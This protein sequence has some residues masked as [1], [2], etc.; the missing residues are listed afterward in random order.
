[1]ANDLGR[2]HSG[3]LNTVRL[4]LRLARAGGKARMA[5]VMIGASVGSV[6]ILI[7]ASFQH[8]LDTSWQRSL[9]RT[10]Y[11]GEAAID[12]EW[13][14]LEDGTVEVVRENRVFPT[15]TPDPKSSLYLSYGSMPHMGIDSD[16]ITRFL[17]GSGPVPPGI[18]KLPRTGEAYVSPA[19]LAKIENSSE[20]SDKFAAV[21]LLEISKAGLQNP[22][23]LFAYLPVS[24][25]S[26]YIAE[27]DEHPVLSWGV[28]YGAMHGFLNPHQ[29][30][31]FPIFVFLLLPAVVLLATT[32]R[33]ASAVRTERMAGLRLLG[34][35]K[36]RTRL[37][38]GIE[39]GG[40]AVLGVVFG[41]ALVPLIGAMT[42]G[43][44]IFEYQW[45]ASDFRPSLAAFIT[46]LLFVPVL[47]VATTLVVLRNI[48][49]NPLQTRRKGANPRPSLWRL[50]PVSF[51]AA[52]LLFTSQRGF[53]FLDDTEA[54]AAI[55]TFL[56]GAV[57]VGIGLILAVPVLVRRLAA[58]LATTTSRS[59]VLL[60][61]RRTQYEPAV[62]NR[63]VTGIVL[64]L[65]IAT[66]GQAVIL[67]FENTPQ[68]RAAYAS[69]SG[70]YAPMGVMKGDAAP[71]D[72]LGPSSSELEAIPNV[73]GATPL[74]MLRGNATS[75][76]FGDFQVRALIASCAEL[77]ELGDFDGSCIDAE[78]Q[79]LSEF[80][81][82]FS[83]LVLRN[84]DA[85]LELGSLAGEQAA[86]KFENPVL[87]SVN[88]RIPPNL[89]Q[90]AQLGT[91][92]PQ[93]WLLAVPTD[94]D[95]WEA[96]AAEIHELSPDYWAMTPDTYTLKEVANVRFGIWLGTGIA[97]SIAIFTLLITAI[98]NGIARR[99]QIAM[100]RA[101]GVSLGRVRRSQ[102][103]QALLPLA[104]G[105]PL[106]GVAGV[107]AG[108]AYIAID[109]ATSSQTYWSA[110]GITLAL[111]V[112]AA[113]LVAAATLPAIGGKITPRSLRRE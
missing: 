30:T 110:I 47:T 97:G 75:S 35:S 72:E 88:L 20:L 81:G 109:Y 50:V 92:E 68:Y 99:P 45:F 42:E 95:T 34:V 22:G 65:F 77:T 32:T 103:L 44:E 52:V 56:L 7:S 57:L 90:L 14:E 70:D 64:V 29:G 9:D 5:L 13:I 36:F 23:E 10:A 61:A 25:N 28:H 100:Q 85:Q 74:Y 112:A 18:P 71:A 62:V 48:S 87:P 79:Q 105:V 66:G 106:A 11:L 82:D 2:R 1:M 38:A 49:N 41:V 58:W 101:F 78:P 98:D 91:V 84:G 46:I 94:P 26:E 83:N 108:Q 113:I 73:H 76:T 8:A 40:L 3:L 111:A 24:G 31:S 15:G 19:L 27:T 16:V 89:P 51:G 67:A 63:L 93:D 80:Q 17:E 96:I 12:E 69:V 4:G 53:R 33:L 86:L 43:K 54:T 102:V 59:T 37:I 21:E 39:A 107:L 60:A 104:V 55:Y 6:L